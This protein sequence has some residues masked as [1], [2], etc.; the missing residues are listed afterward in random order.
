MV[1]DCLW[2]SSHTFLED[3]N[4]LGLFKTT[5]HIKSQIIGIILTSALSNGILSHGGHLE[6][7]Y[8]L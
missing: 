5:K 1:Q 6:K 4:E 3:I 7:S 8:C 2:S